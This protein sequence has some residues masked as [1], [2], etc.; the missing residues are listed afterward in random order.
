MVAASK[1]VDLNHVNLKL[2]D[3]AVVSIEH[4]VGKHLNPRNAVLTIKGLDL[5]THGLLVK[6]SVSSH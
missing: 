5:L 4:I 3:D 6:D 1:R 2:S